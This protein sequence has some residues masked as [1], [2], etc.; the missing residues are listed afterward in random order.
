ML[1]RSP[2]TG[3]AY[4]LLFGFGVFLAMLVFGGL[5]GQLF[6]WMQRWGN[7]FINALR[8][9]VSLVSISYGAK[10]LLMTF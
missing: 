9:V 4:L 5:I 7:K 8:I 10:L 2:W 6:G 3:L 1:F